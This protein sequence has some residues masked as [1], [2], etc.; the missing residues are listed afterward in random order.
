MDIPAVKQDYI[1]E[2][3]NA[4][5]DHGCYCGETF[6]KPVK[7]VKWNSKLYKSAL[8]YAKEMSKYGFFGHYGAQGQNI[9]ERLDAVKYPWEVAGENLGEGQKT[10]DEV[11]RDWIASESHCRMLMNPRVTEMA[12]AKHK[13]FWVQHWGKQMPSGA[14]PA[15]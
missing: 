11:L 6:M 14:V 7:P 9:G 12:V 1:L 2:R 13:Q 4:V 5:R 10:F 3:V 8:S 15:D